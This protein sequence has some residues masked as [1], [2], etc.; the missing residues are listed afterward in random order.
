MHGWIVRCSARRS[1][2]NQFRVLTQERLKSDE[3]ALDDGLDRR[4]E[5]EDRAIDADG[6]D[7]FFESRPVR[8]RIPT[9]EREPRVLVIEG[10]LLNV[11]AGHEFRPPRD[12][13]V[14]EA[15]V[16]LVDDSNRVGVTGAMSFDQIAGLPFVVLE[17]R[18]KWQRLHASAAVP[19]KWARTDF[20][21]WMGNVRSV[22]VISMTSPPA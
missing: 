21:G 19:W 22:S 12:R 8:K 7:V 18:A 3:V 14:Q 2:P 17:W 16:V 4:L 13:L 9:R 15:R 10:R 6:V 1:R 5:P 11:G 20:R